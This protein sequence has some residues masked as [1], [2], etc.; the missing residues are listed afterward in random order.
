MRIVVT[1]GAGFIGSALATEWSSLGHQVLVI[2]DLSAGHVERVPVKCWPG[3]IDVCSIDAVRAALQFR[4]DL[5]SHHAGLI[6]PRVSM[7]DPAKDVSVNVQGTVNMARVAQACDSKFIFASSGAVYGERWTGRI[8]LLAE[9]SENLEPVS[10][11][12][13]SKATA[14]RYL[15]MMLPE[16]QLLIWRYPNVYGP[17]QD[18]AFGTGV[19]AIFIDNVVQG[20]DCMIRGTGKQVY[21]Y[22][23]IDD[24]VKMNTKVAGSKAHGTYNLGGESV[25]VNEIY[26]MVVKAYEKLSGK[27]YK[28]KKVNAQMIPGE[29]RYIAHNLEKLWSLYD[30]LKMKWKDPV[31]VFSGIEM[32][33][34]KRLE[35]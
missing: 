7:E 4:P 11:Y 26:A 34:K 30:E 29:T 24:I 10:V 22:A 20:K 33:M 23:Y 16:K 32:M 8:G 6:D 18:P 27:K 5:I 19:I 14:E 15:R 3:E 28:G 21:D 31:A 12:G 25:S 35:S 17:D 9:E 13:L 1:G 2:D